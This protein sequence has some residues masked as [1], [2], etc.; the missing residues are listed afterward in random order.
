MDKYELSKPDFDVINAALKALILQERQLSKPAIRAEKLRH[1]FHTA[2]T[3]W[4][5]GEEP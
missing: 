4:I 3:A 5:E 1:L 2:H